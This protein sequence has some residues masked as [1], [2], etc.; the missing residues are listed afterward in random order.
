MYA[1]SFQEEVLEEQDI[2]CYR[3][4]KRDALSRHRKMHTDK[5]WPK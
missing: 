2:P 3:H 1:I 5:C 4:F